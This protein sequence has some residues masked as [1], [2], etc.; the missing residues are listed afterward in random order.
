MSGYETLIKTFT[1]DEDDPAFRPYLSNPD[2]LKK[3][4]L[5]PNAVAREKAIECI[6]N[7]VSMGWQTCWQDSRERHALP[8]SD[9]CLGSTRAGAK[10][11]ALEL[12]L[13][14]TEVDGSG[15]RVVV[16]LSSRCSYSD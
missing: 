16:R 8:W 2:I 7:F 10:K 9:K 4:A 1:A 3:T 11:N 5:D 15:V 6:C 13:L 14:Y 12:C